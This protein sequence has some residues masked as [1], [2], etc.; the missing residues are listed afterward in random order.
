MSQ[1]QLMMNIMRKTRREE[2]RKGLTLSGVA[3]EKSE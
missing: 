2:R 1:N 3:V